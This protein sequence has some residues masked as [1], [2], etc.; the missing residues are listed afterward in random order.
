MENK[1]LLLP[2]FV[3]LAWTL[4]MMIWMFVCRVPAIVQMRMRLDP[5]QV[6]GAQMS[7]L[8]PKVR[9]KADNYNHL[10]EQPVLFYAVIL[11]LVFLGETNLLNQSLAW[12]YVGARVVHSLIQALYNNILHRFAVFIFSSVV[13]LALVFRGCFALIA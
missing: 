7:E 11:G 4:I 10:L 9:W 3:L 2:F 1:D 6:R 5:N 8:P 13:L 12:I